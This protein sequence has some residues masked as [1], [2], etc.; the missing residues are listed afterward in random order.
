MSPTQKVESSSGFYF[1]DLAAELAET[2]HPLA[3]DQRAQRR[4]LRR[5]RQW[6]E[7]RA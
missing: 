7:A 6:L 1:L 4:T 5:Y 3:C 2:S